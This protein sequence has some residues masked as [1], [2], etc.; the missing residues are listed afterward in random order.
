M[1][2]LSYADFFQ[3]KLFKKFFQKHYQSV[4]QFLD[5]DLGRQHVG[6]DPGQ[7][8]ATIIGRRQNLPLAKELIQI[9]CV[10]ENSVDPNQLA[11]SEAS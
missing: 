8:F 4:K 11:L 10:D 9:H 1:L 6:P 3:N 2:L 7:L 5:P